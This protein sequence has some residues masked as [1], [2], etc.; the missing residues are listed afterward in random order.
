MSSIKFRFEVWKSYVNK[1]GEMLLNNEYLISE[2]F[3]KDEDNYNK[4]K[5][6]YENNFIKFKAKERFTIPIIGKISSGKSTFL[7]SIL[8][9]NYLS[10]SSNIDTKFVCI[11]RH[12]QNC[13]SPK[14][15]NC[16]L[17]QEK[18][19]YK[20][21]DFE[22]YYFEKTEELKGDVL[23]N[24]KGI[25]QNLNKYEKEV[26]IDERDINKYFYILELNIPLFNENK[27]LGDYFELMD[28]PGLNE[29]NDFYIQKIIPTLVNKCLFSIYIFDLEKYRNDDTCLIYKN[30]SQQLINF[31]I[32]IQ[33]IF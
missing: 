24:I 12:K 14:L 10:C 9:G 30:Y 31:I 4:F 7:N 15:F 5:E 26:N 13:K 3:K 11:L 29:E 17:K 2:I 21:R 1:I 18:I 25:N 6:D 16:V 33:Y 23:E 22:Y 20:Y 32:Q 28:I 8:L 19:D 27:E